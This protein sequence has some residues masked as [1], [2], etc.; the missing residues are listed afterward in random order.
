MSGEGRVF[1][2]SGSALTA[3][4]QD[5]SFLCEKLLEISVAAKLLLMDKDCDAYVEN[6]RVT[7]DKVTRECQEYG[8]ND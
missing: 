1:V 7:V 8:R 2:S 4:R 3:M 6:L 5:I